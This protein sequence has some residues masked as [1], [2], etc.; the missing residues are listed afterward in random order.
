MAAK[1][2]WQTGEMVTAAAMNALGAEVNAQVPVGRLPVGTSANTVAAGNDSRFEN[3]RVP[4]N[5]SVTTAKIVDQAVTV[6]KLG[7][8]VWA[9]LV[10]P[11]DISLI[12]AGKD[13]DREV[14]L[15]DNPF[16]VKL[17]R[18][19]VVESFHP[20][21]ITADGSGNL[22]LELRKNGAAVAGTSH[23]IA[24][25]S[26]VAGTS[27]TGLAIAYAAGDILTVQI[28]GV[29][30]SPGKGLVVDVKGRVA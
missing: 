7:P 5:N 27:R 2:D 6:A 29:G 20:R 15:N 18:A 19:I 22:T 24:A 10:V 28:T 9:A 26:Q 4:T 13:S 25:G 3:Q 1:T 21:C 8:D 12:V 14:G 17:Q 16:G 30:G 23:S 11:H